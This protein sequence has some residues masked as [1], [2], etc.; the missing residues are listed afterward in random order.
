MKFL[1][2]RNLH[3]SDI[4]DILFRNDPITIDLTL[5][6]SFLKDEKSN[7]LSLAD[8]QD[9]IKQMNSNFSQETNLK[10]YDLP[11]FNRVF[12]FLILIHLLRQKKHV[13]KCTIDLLAKVVNKSYKLD[14]FLLY[15]YNILYLFY[16]EC[17]LGN[18]LESMTEIHG[19]LQ[20][21][22]EILLRI[23]EKCYN[24]SLLLSNMNELQE[25]LVL[26]IISFSLSLEQNSISN[27]FLTIYSE[28]K[29][30]NR[31]MSETSET[32]LSLL[33]GT[34][35]TKGIPNHYY[36]SYIELVGAC[37]SYW[38]LMVDFIAEE[39]N[40]EESEGSSNLKVNLDNLEKN[41]HSLNLLVHSTLS[42]LLALNT[43]TLYRLK[44][45]KDIGFV[46][47]EETLMKIEKNVLNETTSH[48]NLVGSS[49]HKFGNS[50]LISFRLNS[51]VKQ[52]EEL[53]TIE[54]F[55]ALQY[56]EALH[57]KLNPSQKPE[58]KQEQE[59]VKKKEEKEEVK[60]KEEKAPQ[61]KENIVKKLQVGK[62]TL[63]LLGLYLESLANSTEFLDKAEKK[64]EYFKKNYFSFKNQNFQNEVSLLISSKNDE[65]RKPKIP[66]G[67]R[68][69]TPMQMALRKKVFKIITDVFLKHGAV[70][71]DTPVFELK[72]T[73]TGKYGEDSKLIYD[74]QDQGG[75]LLSLRYD[76]TVPFARY[77][78]LK[79]ITNIKR[80]H[81]AKVY[82]RDNPALNKGRFREFYQCDF[83]IAG[84]YDVML[85]DAEVIKVLDEILTNLGMGNFQ[86]K[87]NNRKLLDAM[88]ELSG[89]P[90]QKFKQICSS[91]D[92]LDKV[93]INFTLF[94]INLI[95]TMV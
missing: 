85:P 48:L 36:V 68:D 61:K 72:E 18:Q 22:Y 26:S 39:L 8:I 82:R 71:I 11:L 14:Q 29:S 79:N 91:I 51:Y 75:E 7:R 17:G 89:A 83:D 55:L 40:F 63:S 19:L 4:A 57:H 77:L 84:N 37:K 94:Y 58:N 90:K 2:A 93:L 86:I 54:A 65:R 49:P 5:E 38:K 78:A 76:L 23:I 15:P 35:F 31:M 24:Y 46:L 73:L 70:E 69:F 9:H 87:V 1:G 16:G 33:I 10:D 28:K 53:I 3:Y 47:I 88:V 81:I 43:N 44:N 42:N 67:T 45:L 12:V 25:L 56:L 66:K 6:S 20:T 95:G 60:K 52:F 92:K 59:E 50:F 74:L 27:D 41:F 21:E 32:I 34:K 30:L 64:F 62:G 13:R 80:Y